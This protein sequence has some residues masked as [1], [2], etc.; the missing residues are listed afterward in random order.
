MTVTTEIPGPPWRT[1]DELHEYALKINPRGVVT[2]IAAGPDGIRTRIAPVIE[3]KACTVE[4]CFN[5]NDPEAQRR[6]LLC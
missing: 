6:C 2:E 1:L 4:E 3:A 5:Q